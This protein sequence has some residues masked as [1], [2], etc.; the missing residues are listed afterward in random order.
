M[1]NADA[2]GPFDFHETRQFIRSAIG[3]SDSRNHR[4]DVD[5]AAEELTG[6]TFDAAVL[7]QTLEAFRLDKT[8]KTTYRMGTL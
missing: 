1:S 3:Q 4:F 8:S 6:R 7:W 2:Y 5:T